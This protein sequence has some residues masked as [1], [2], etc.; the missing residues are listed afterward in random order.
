MSKTFKKHPYLILSKCSHPR[1]IRN[2]TMFSEGLNVIDF[3]IS[4]RRIQS[5]FLIILKHCKETSFSHI[6]RRTE[7]KEIPFNRILLESC[8]S[9]LRKHRVNFIIVLDFPKGLNVCI[10]SS[11]PSEWIKSSIQNFIGRLLPF[12]SLQN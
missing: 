9:F 6:S 12:H 4:F 5:C 8:F 10:R 11:N 7:S 3:V 1:K 2:F